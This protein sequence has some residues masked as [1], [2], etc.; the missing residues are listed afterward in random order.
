M[1]PLCP[2]SWLSKL[3]L[4]WVAL[5]MWQHLAT[6]ACHNDIFLTRSGFWNP[7]FLGN[8]NSC[9]PIVFQ[10]PV[11]S[12]FVPHATWTRGRLHATYYNHFMAGQPISNLY[13]EKNSLFKLVSIQLPISIASLENLSGSSL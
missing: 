9:T 3:E 13:L 10:N 5:Q 6:I 1:A 11:A 2:P 4:F 12:T 8:F 7:A